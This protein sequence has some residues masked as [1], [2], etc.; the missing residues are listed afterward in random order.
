MIVGTM[1]TALRH[2]APRLDPGDALPLYAQ[3][4]RLLA[5]ELDA[6]LRA[7]A[8]RPGD[9]FTTEGDLCRR[10]GVSNITAR[11]AMNELEAEGRL[12]RQRGRGT[13]VA[14]PRLP[15]ELDRFDRFSASVREHG[16]KPSCRTLAVRRRTAAGAVACALDL[17]PARRVI[18]IERLRAVN[19]EPYFL[20][21]SFLCP[22]RLPGIEAQDH[23][24]RGLYAILAEDYH[25]RP[26][27]CVDSFEPVVLRR[28]ESQLL[29]SAPG[30]P[31]MRV[32]RIT[33][34][35]DTPVEYSRGVMRGDRCRLVVD[36]SEARRMAIV[37][38]PAAARR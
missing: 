32:E 38:R 28:R 29:G 36:L 34:S 4:R 2:P 30:A 18:E 1:A 33:Y 20:H 26:T 14:Q 12:S 3:L 10:F 22:K 23:E 21:S 25:L 8:C 37:P 7:G 17:A 16:M 6:K 24:K 11:R 15:Q 9:F 19:G 13:F 5:A 27:R 31:G 35:G